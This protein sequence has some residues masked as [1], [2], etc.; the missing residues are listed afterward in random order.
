MKIAI[1]DDVLLFRKSIKICLENY[2]NKYQLKSE[3]FLYESSEYLK[4][5][6]NHGKS[7][8]LIFLDIE[9]P[10]VNGIEI[11]EAIKKSSTGTRII[12][13]TSHNTYVSQA[14]SLG[15][16]QYLEK[17][18]NEE[19]FEKEMNRFLK[20]YEQSHYMYIVKWQG[21]ETSLAIKEI[22]YLETER[23]KIIVHT[24][25]KAYPMVS[26]MDVEEE[27]LKLYCFIR[28]HRAFLV[29]MNYIVG[30]KTGEI[31]IRC[32]K[33]KISLAV[34]KERIKTVRLAYVAYKSKVG[35]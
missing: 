32:G 24:K 2:L 34:S 13:V 18:L 29:N 4:E 11:G 19:I 21:E 33:E 17:P 22:I 27:R 3:I 10:G 8:D 5:E 30:F 35:I 7:W 6:I 28:I 31:E 15:A 25:E 26:K 23:R 20:N 14:F 9:M 12:Y 1:C 16:F